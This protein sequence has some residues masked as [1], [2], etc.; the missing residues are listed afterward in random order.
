[1]IRIL[2]Y[3][4]L[5][6]LHAIPHLVTAQDSIPKKAYTTQYLGD[7][8]APK[9]D[10]DLS[11]VAWKIVS[12]GQDYIE[13]SPEEN[14]PPTEQTQFKIVYD[15]KNLYVAFRCFDKDP[16]GIVNRL[17]RRDGFDGDWVEIN[18]GSLGDKRTAF[19]FT[20]S[21]S[22][23]KGEEF[24]T[25]DGARWDN[26]WNPIWYAKTRIDQDG[27]TAEIRIPLSQ[28]RFNKDSE[29]IW[30]LQSTRRYFRKEERS[31]WQ[32]SPQNVAGWVS[33]FG[34]LHGL[35][36]LKPQKQLELQPYVV[37]ALK[38]YEAEEGNPFRDGNDSQ[39]SFGIDGKLGIT[40]DITLDF[41]V[42]PDFGQV[43]ADPSAIALDGFQIFFPEQRPFFIENKNIFDYRFSESAANNRTL[44]FD[45]LFYS[46]RIGRAPQGVPAIH[47]DEF[48]EPIDVTS[49]LG[50]A[51]FSGKTKNGWSM[52]F[53][54]SVTANEKVNISNG[55]QT[56]KETVEPLT[57]Y[58]VGRVQK[59]FNANSSFIGGI[60][61]ATNRDLSPNV[62]FLHRS[63][64]TGGIDA[65]HQW[66]NRA[67]YLKTNFVFSHV[68]G[69]EEAIERTQRS[70]THLFQR[71]GADYLGVN[72]NKTSLTGT[73]GNLQMG[74]ASG[75]WRFQSGITWRSPELELNDVG[76]QLK[77]DDIRHYGW[78]GYR[79]TKPLKSMR[80]WLV[81]Y[82]HLAVMDFDKNLNQLLFNLNTWMNLKNNLWANA[83]LQIEPVLFS[84]TAL[85]GGPRLKL[86]SAYQGGININSDGRK[87]FRYSLSLSTQQLAHNA[88]NKYYIGGSLTYQPTNAL[89]I[90]LL[91]SYT[92]NK[93]RLQYVTSRDFLG[94]NRY[95]NG[96]INQETLSFPLRID[97]ILNPNLSIQYWGQ[98]FISRGRYHNFKYITNPTGK[99]FKNRFHT[100][101]PEQISLSENNY[102]I[103]EGGIEGPSADY[104]FPR[105][106]FSFIQW[107]SNLVLR[108]EYIPGSEVYLVWSQ[109]LSRFG[110]FREGL[111]EGLANNITKPQNIF[112]V[113][114]TYR[115]M[116]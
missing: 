38:T 32:R 113:K 100:Y 40:N 8:P 64:Y 93:D 42:N 31:V 105:P 22:G 106:D 13:W 79:T 96:T 20:I 7:N 46:R 41:T 72:P 30:G 94:K 88:A 110:D 97:Y 75:N 3:T 66:K 103:F 11:D 58:F 28:L 63:A 6:I 81:N 47:E 67:F 95:I 112:L 76:F 91:P 71:E 53:L 12:W 16:G 98:P 74:K 109:D 59:D 36:N 23:V 17:S 43:E 15:D 52:G 33:S 48:Y 55:T 85:R 61:T 54:E 84:N 86:P 89:Q 4:I 116:K 80:S 87:K 24:I 49:I 29:Q 111:W 35:K 1:M 69:T 78:L 101:Q 83:F 82:N 19:S 70:I 5:L 102:L 65:T 92:K 14:T 37:G 39:L 50:A 34:E 68:N 108:W 73:G 107:R 104:Q 115:F 27:W 90:S 21:V 99:S 2:T 45:N 56:R 26:T 62:A 60:F 9:L 10:G 18:I 51:K 114:A 77:A 25:N 44:G 57:N